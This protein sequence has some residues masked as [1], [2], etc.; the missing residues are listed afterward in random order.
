MEIQKINAEQAWVISF[1]YAITFKHCKSI[2]GIIYDLKFEEDVISFTAPSRNEG[3]AEAISKESFVEFYYL[4][5]NLEVINTNTIKK[6]MPSGFYKKRSLFI[7]L[8]ST[9]EI[10]K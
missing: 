4:L 7:A 1:Q 3:K 8:L 6:I 5:N 9:C 10:I 2:S